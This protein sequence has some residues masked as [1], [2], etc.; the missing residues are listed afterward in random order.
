MVATQMALELH[1]AKRKM[2]ETIK[3]LRETQADISFRLVRGGQLSDHEQEELKNLCG[4]AEKLADLLTQL[5]EQIIGL[6]TALETAPE[7][8]IN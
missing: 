1:R 5:Q 6:E 7:G 4:E 8:G 2:L 3:R